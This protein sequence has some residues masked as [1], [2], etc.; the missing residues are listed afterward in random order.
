MPNRILRDWTD[1]DKVNQL[2]PTAEVFFVR[3]IMKADDFGR[4][5][6]DPRRLRSACYPLKDS[7]RDT[8][9]SRW[10]A[11][12]EKAGLIRC[13]DATGCRYLC[14]DN[15][16]QRL[17]LMKEKHPAPPEMSVTRPSSDGHAPAPFV[18]VSDSDSD[19]Q[20][21]LEGAGRKGFPVTIDDALAQCSIAAGYVPKEFVMH[22]FDKA[23]SR[24]GCD[25]KEIPIG[26]F[27]AYVRTQWKYE[28]DR[29]GREDANHANHARPNAKSPVKNDDY[30][31]HGF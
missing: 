8:D 31:K 13:Y 3:L 15:F 28:Q 6:A 23:E 17:R 1:S 30:Y 18:S 5:H 10:L 14:I 20:K 27:A 16:G 4:F 25:D 19:S 26:N 24:G 7:I 2:T 12:C 11:E 22:C 9:I 29:K 21:G